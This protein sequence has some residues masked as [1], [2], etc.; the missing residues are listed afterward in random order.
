MN[1][2]R[3]LL[4]FVVSRDKVVF[5]YQIVK[6]SVD[7]DGI[8][9]Y[10][11]DKTLFGFAF[12]EQDS[13]KGKNN[14]DPNNQSKNSLTNKSIDTKYSEYG[15]IMKIFRRDKELI[16]SQQQEVNTTVLTAIGLFRCKILSKSDKFHRKAEV[17]VLRD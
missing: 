5:P 1:Q 11:D 4:D 7:G 10:I 3:K 9:N 15:T 13:S 14:D 2:T 12:V 8:Q 17:E 6:F 16:I